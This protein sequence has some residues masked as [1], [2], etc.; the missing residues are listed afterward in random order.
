[1]FLSPAS[2]CVIYDKYHYVQVSD[3]AC[4]SWFLLSNTSFWCCSVPFRGGLGFPVLYVCYPAILFS[5]LDERHEFLFFSPF[6]G[7]ISESCMQCDSTG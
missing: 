1:M 7:L 4:R 3:Y 5:A 2:A 6:A